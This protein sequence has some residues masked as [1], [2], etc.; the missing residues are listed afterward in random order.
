MNQQLD[1]K[2]VNYS[3]TTLTELMIPAYA[4]FGRKNSWWYFIITNGIR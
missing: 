2:P 1:Y 3:Q 4:N